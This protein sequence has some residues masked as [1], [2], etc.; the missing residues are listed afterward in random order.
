MDTSLNAS[1]L[2]TLFGGSSSTGIGTDLL[3]NYFASQLNTTAANAA[4]S[5]GTSTLGP[6]KTTS[7]TGQADA[8]DAPW[9]GTTSMP[10]ESALVQKVMAG[11]NFIN[12]NAVTSNVNGSSP[13]YTKLFTLYQGLNALEGIATAAQAKNISA[14]QLAEYQRRFTQGM[15]EVD[16]YIGSTKYDHVSLT[17]GT[18]TSD[19]RNTVGA[20][21]NNTTYIGQNIATGS[22]STAVKA[23]DGDVQFSMSIKRIGTKDP[24]VVNFNLAD[25]GT[26]PRSMSN[27]VNYMNDQLKAAGVSTRMAVNRTPATPTTTTVNGVT[28]TLSAGTDTFGLEV[29]GS[30]AETVTF[31]A[32]DTA[33]SVYVV[34]TTGDPTKK[35]TSTSSTDPSSSTSSSSTTP[36]NGTDVTS[37]VMKFQTDVVTSGTD[38]SAPIGKPGD[39]YW[40]AGESE[41]IQLP[42]SLANIASTTTG[43]TT[44]KSLTGVRASVAGP[45][46]SLYVLADVNAQTGGQ[47]IKGTQDVALM[48]YDSAGNLVYTRTLG[49][50]DTA[51][52]SSIAVSADG[53]VAIAGSVTGALDVASTTTAKDGTVTTTSA[54]D[55]DG[56]NATTSDSFVQVF[57]ANGVPQ[58]TQRF[59]SSNLDQ[60]TTVTFDANDNVY[61]G[62][63]TM[64]TMTGATANGGKGEQ[65][66]WDAYVAGFSA[67]GKSTFMQQTGTAQSDATSQVAVS[68]TTMYVASQ[69]NNTTVLSSYDIS[70]GKPTLIASRDLG[71][72]G[73]GN[74][75]GISVY[76]GQVY[77]G[78]SSGSGKLLDGTANVTAAYSG[79][80][81]A[82]ALSVN[83]D[84]TKTTNDTVAYYGGTGSEKN[85][86]VQFANGVAYMSG[87][88][89]G[90]ITGTTQTG[91]GDA[92][93]ASLNLATG[94]VLSQT[95][96]SGTDGLV[97]P[98]SIAVSAGSSSVLDKLGLPMG[99]VLQTD[100]PNIVANTS[101]RTGDQF[102]MVDPNTGEKKTIT[103]D[104]TDTMKTLAN[105]IQRASGYQLTVTTTTVMGKN[106]APMR[107][108]L[109][110]KP[111]NG[112]S[113]M[114]FLAGPAGKDALAGLGLASGLVTSQAG[115]IMDPNSASYTS[116]QKPMG[117]SFDTALNLN[118]ATNI[119]AAIS[120]LQATMQKV[121]SVYT[122]LSRGDPQP[123]KKT[124]AGN[125]SSAPPTY[126]TNEIAN[127]QAALQRLT[128]GS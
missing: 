8:P 103:I 75:S 49:A 106:G 65:G 13:D 30:S 7:P 54:G 101:V 10:D 100:S 84:L 19:L 97:S 96:Y 62:G 127:Y 5:S 94:Q 99:T 117:L 25:M 35:L 23:F 113:S 73:G 21:E 124:G 50:A 61:V 123:A 95:R 76:N 24:I 68:G 48:K 44:T 43:S 78:G 104:A 77:L 26:E 98:D 87:Q 31:G 60:A 71:G 82:F 34:Q 120:S 40:T 93:L 47:D 110:I 29:K 45:D 59:G 108:G 46:G 91:K 89:T 27:V 55:L 41:Q 121:Q 39:T 66:G 33:Q 52:A 116:S 105:K 56:A 126:L 88:T 90:A 92:Y 57:D 109:D 38:P 70:S 74:I 67:T 58:W 114:E 86:Q 9:L 119:A 72:L 112:S 22:A 17:E 69:Q 3:S 111:A 1:L 115:Q 79:S 118:S 128:G 4:S 16:Q 36:A 63:K 12:P 64:A 53:K 83:A 122:Y 15:A 80:Y 6:T 11:Q 51:S 32:P 28:K 18:L 14:N 85:A 2:S 37:Q 42:D 107:Q 81:D 125:T 20:A 102:Y